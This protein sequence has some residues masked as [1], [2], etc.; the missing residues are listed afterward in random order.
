[1]AQVLTEGTQSASGSA[2]SS[3]GKI[4]NLSTVG[5]ADRRRLD[6]PDGWVLETVGRCAIGWA[7]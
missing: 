2:S 4:V 7:V 6:V 1:M 3:K 5:F